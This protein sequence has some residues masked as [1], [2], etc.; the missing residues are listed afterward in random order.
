M[1]D[2]IGIPYQILNIIILVRIQ[3]EIG[4]AHE[5]NRTEPK[6]NDYVK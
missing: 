5:E 2:D 4:I 1:S 3:E 6:P